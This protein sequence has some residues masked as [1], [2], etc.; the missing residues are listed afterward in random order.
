ILPV[1]GFSILYYMAL[2]CVS[3]PVINGLFGMAARVFAALSRA[4]ISV[5]LITQSSSEYCFSFCVPLS[6]C[7][8][9]RRAMQDEFYL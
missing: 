5:V 4:G 9:A 8:R 6:V 2:F 7:A 3:V 1:I